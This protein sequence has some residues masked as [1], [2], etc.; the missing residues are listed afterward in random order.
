[1]LARVT[2]SANLWLPRLQALQRSYM[3]TCALLARRQVPSVQG[4][5]YPFSKAVTALRQFA[6]AR[7]VGKILLHLPEPDAVSGGGSC[8][9]QVS[10]M[11]IPWRV[12]AGMKRS[13]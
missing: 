1:M 11:G 10:S 7:H 6:H 13:R 3:R 5:A 8:Q 4:L 12:S 9:A 2:G